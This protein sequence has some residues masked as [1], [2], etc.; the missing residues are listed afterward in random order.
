MNNRWVIK[1]ISSKRRPYIRKIVKI[2]IKEPYVPPYDPKIGF[3][4]NDD[5]IIKPT[6]SSENKI[7]PKPTKNRPFILSPVGLIMIFITLSYML[8]VFSFML[9]L[10]S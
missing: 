3:W 1:K 2:K 10:F 8:A 7:S 5:N 4:E 9:S 6:K